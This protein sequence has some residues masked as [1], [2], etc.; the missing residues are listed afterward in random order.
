M[1][2]RLA[3]PPT[4]WASIGLE[5]ARTYAA[6][7]GW[8]FEVATEETIR[9]PLLGN[10]RFLLPYRRQAADPGRSC[11][12]LDTL[13]EAGTAA[14]GELLRSAFSSL[15]DQQRGLPCLWHLVATGRIAA[16]LDRPLTMA[17]PLRTA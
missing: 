9:T 2:A 14:A 6:G 1:G 7:R 16:N 5:A 15:G 13:S 11:R 17:S 4:S 12:L 10:A 8:S 3:T